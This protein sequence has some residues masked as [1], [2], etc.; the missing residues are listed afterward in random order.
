MSEEQQET[1]EQRSLTKLGKGRSFT[2]T[3]SSKT[4][5]DLL[6]KI[7]HENL[8]WKRFFSFLVQG[9]LDDDQRIMSYLDERMLN[10]RT[11]NRTS[12]LQKERILTQET[13]DKFGLNED[14]IVNIYEILEEEFDP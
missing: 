12:V 2:F 8:G 4:Y 5:M 7:R 6:I 1:E 11:K 14:E 13:K 10:I 9:F 3:L